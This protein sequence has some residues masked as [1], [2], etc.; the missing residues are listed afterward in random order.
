MSEKRVL[1]DSERIETNKRIAEQYYLAY[2]EKAVKDGGTYADWVYA[3]HAEYWS[4]YFGNGMID[5]ETNP[6]SVEDSA[7]MEA[8][9]Y[10]IEFRDWAP[11]DFESF[12]TVEGAAWK[13]HFGGYRKKDDVFMDFFVYSF[14]RTNEYGEIKHWETHVNSDYND[15]LDV[16]IGE[17]GP[18]RNGADQYM[19]AVMRKLSSAGIDLASL[20]HKK[21]DTSSHT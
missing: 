5:L 15:F 6:I 18:Y 14:I 2:K 21:G 19:Q 20:A 10:S 7:T 17:H 4:P 3:S 13:T 9:A 8:L 11:I 16:A 12:P 1:T